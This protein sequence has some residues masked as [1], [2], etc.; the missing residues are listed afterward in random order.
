MVVT[1][2]EDFFNMLLHKGFPPKII[3]LRMGNQST[4]SVAATLRIHQESIQSLYDDE[5][6]GIIEIF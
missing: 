4:K 5:F 1:N 6:Y 3:M 2:D